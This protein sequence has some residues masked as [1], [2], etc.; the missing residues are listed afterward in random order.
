MKTS[1]TN[2]SALS[3]CIM[4]MTEKKKKKKL[5]KNGESVLSMGGASIST[6]KNN[7]M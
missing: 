1:N 5:L 2:I 3:F 7:I 4:L 6:D